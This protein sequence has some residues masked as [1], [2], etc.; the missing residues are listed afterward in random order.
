MSS[1]SVVVVSQGFAG[2]A[3]ATVES[4]RFD[5]TSV[6]GLHASGVAFESHPYAH[7]CV[8]LIVPEAEHVTRLLP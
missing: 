7:G 3:G 8:E 6:G 1:E 5:G 2:N 4:K